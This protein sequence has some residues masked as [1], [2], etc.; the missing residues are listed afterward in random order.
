MYLSFGA[1]V[2]FALIFL[3]A[4]LR[5]G[6][7]PAA[8]IQ[9][10]RSL[11]FPRRLSPGIAWMVIAYEAVLGLLFLAGFLPG[12]ALIAALLLL[13]AFAGVSLFALRS[14]QLIP[15]ACFG[16][17]DTP[18]GKH[19]LWRALL[20]AVPVVLYYLGTRETATAWWPAGLDTW[21]SLLT[22]VLASLLLVR[23]LLAVTN[24]RTLMQERKRGEQE[25]AGHYERILIERLRRQGA[26]L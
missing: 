21:V 25:L 1:R 8:F 22:L 9:T 11:G 2:F 20:L 12:I 7:Q 3:V 24:I 4:A 15:C 13:A 6:L 23:W 19:T 26:P 5:K 18:L 17:A 10:I 14:A 16:E